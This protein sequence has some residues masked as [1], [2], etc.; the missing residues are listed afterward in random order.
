MRINVDSRI[1]YPINGSIEN[2]QST[3]MS[4]VKSNSARSTN[5]KGL[6][7]EECRTQRMSQN[8]IEARLLDSH[9]VRYTVSHSIDGEEP[10][11]GGFIRRIQLA[12]I[13]KAMRV[14]FRCSCGG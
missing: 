6:T 9:K 11:N 1:L 12:V 8:G 5:R 4:N 2:I 13:F 3:T 10:L 14:S 7:F